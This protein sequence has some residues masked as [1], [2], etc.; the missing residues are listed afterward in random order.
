MYTNMA[1]RMHAFWVSNPVTPQQV[2]SLEDEL[3]V[4][5]SHEQSVSLDRRKKEREKKARRDKANRACSVRGARVREKVFGQS[6]LGL[7]TDVPNVLTH[8]STQRTHAYT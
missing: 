4:V 6:K 5:L 2:Q 7:A 1:A 3:D 8:R